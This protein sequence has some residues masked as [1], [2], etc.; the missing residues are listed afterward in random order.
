[1][2]EGET[3]VVLK[4][5]DR[6]IQL[7]T[8]LTVF[9]R[10][11]PVQKLLCKRANHRLLVIVDHILKELIDELHLEV[12]QVETCVVVA[13]ELVCEV[14]HYLI[15]LALLRWVDELVY[16]TLAE[17]LH[18]AMARDQTVKFELNLVC[19]IQ[20]RYAF[21][22]VG[23]QDALKIEILKIRYTLIQDYLPIYLPLGL[24][25]LSSSRLLPRACRH[26]QDRPLPRWA[27]PPA[28][29]PFPD[30]RRHAC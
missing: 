8:V 5:R 23:D 26:R 10:V 9:V 11:Q 19:G 16:Q 21:M 22:F 20:I 7:I 14:E 4:L 29:C 12:G 6:K 2:D 25:M 13:I 18:L 24:R 28:P 17:V 3:D 1:M 15:T 30:P 27:A